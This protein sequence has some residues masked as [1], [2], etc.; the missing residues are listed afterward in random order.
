M[1]G[2][3][4]GGTRGV[5]HIPFG[6]SRG[7]CPGGVGGAVQRPRGHGGVP[8]PAR[9]SP[10]HAPRS[11]DIRAGGARVHSFLPF[12]FGLRCFSCRGRVLGGLRPQPG[13]T[14]C[15]PGGVGRQQRGGRGRPR[16]CPRGDRGLRGFLG[17]GGPRPKGRQRPSPP[18][19]WPNG[20]P[21]P[22]APSLRCHCHRLKMLFF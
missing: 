20:C 11:A 22:P 2:V 9:G 13:R 8:G 18:R 17:V 19:G 16:W 7:C 1:S 21:V 15:R 3:P 10:R 6:Q 12:K 14:C 5:L 4:R